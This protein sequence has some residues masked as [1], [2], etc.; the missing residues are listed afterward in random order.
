MKKTIF[1]TGGAG[2][3]GVHTLVCLLDAGHRVLVLDDFSNSSQLALA[4]VE[5]ITGVDVPFVRGDVRDM[6]ILKRL[7]AECAEKGEPVS[8]VLHFAALKAVGESVSHPLRYYDVNVAGTL[9]LLAAMHAAEIRKM[10][11]SSSATVYRPA[12][13]L[14]YT[15]QHAIGPSNPYGQTK[16][17]VEQIL[18]DH[19]EANRDFTGIA[20][21]YFNPI[22]AHGSGQIGD[23]PLGIPNNLFPYITRAAIG[24]LPVLPVFGTDYPTVDGSGVRDYIHV[25]DLA[26]GHV[27]AVDWASENDV[28]GFHSFN[29]GTG[30]GTS[31]LQLIQTFEATNGVSVPFEVRGRRNGDIAEAWADVSAANRI[32]KWSAMHSLE[33]MCRDG[34]NWQQKNP[35]GYVE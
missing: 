15:E 2:Y 31:V 14:P 6:G 22:G 26:A 18:R 17:M 7:F 19:C 23:Q 29:L 16:A 24:S 28:R 33:D 30:R 21:R 25:S 34:W 12:S 32:L 20:L 11:F 9:N 13:D 10:V 5:K 1:V 3:I 8:C 27:K 4:R 35:D